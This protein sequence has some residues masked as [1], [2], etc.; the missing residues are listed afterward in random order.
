[1]PNNWSAGSEYDKAYGGVN[2]GYDE[3]WEV[4]NAGRVVT[5]DDTV[6]TSQILRFRRSEN[7]C[8][9]V[10]GDTK[11]GAYIHQVKCDK[12][13]PAQR[14]ILLNKNPSDPRSIRIIPARDTR[15]A[16]GPQVPVWHDT[17]VTL[18]SNSDNADW[19]FNRAD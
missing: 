15:L 13:D 8:M 10:D 14:W 2:P 7:M 18:Q 5:P 19:H 3:A 4:E 11:Q 6:M 17:Y 1:M 12:K 9:A 16:V